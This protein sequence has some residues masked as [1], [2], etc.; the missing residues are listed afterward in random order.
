MFMFVNKM[1]FSPSGNFS[2]A[3]S[4]TPDKGY[5]FIEIIAQET[6]ILTDSGGNMVSTTFPFDIVS[7]LKWYFISICLVLW[8]LLAIIMLHRKNMYPLINFWLPTSPAQLASTYLL[9]QGVAWT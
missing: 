5:L 7:L 9:E 3:K 2:N 6:S 8:W 1:I 4:L